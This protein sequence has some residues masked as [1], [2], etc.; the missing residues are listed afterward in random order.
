VKLSLIR[1]VLES[2]VEEPKQLGPPRKLRL[3]KEQESKG[4]LHEEPLIDQVL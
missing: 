2:T 4:E 3:V 1:K